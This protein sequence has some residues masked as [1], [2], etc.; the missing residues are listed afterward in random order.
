MNMK[1]IL[2]IILSIGLAVSALAGCGT[3]DETAG[4]G[5]GAGADET[6]VGTTTASAKESGE[7]TEITGDIEFLERPSL[8]SGE[9]T[10]E[11]DPDLKPDVAAYTVDDDFGNIIN[12]DMFEYASD[13]YKEAIKENLFVV[14]EEFGREFFEVYESNAY[15]QTPNF[16]TVDSLMHTYHIYFAH[17]LK[18][19]EKNYLLDSLKTLSNNMFA[20]SVEKYDE[21]KGTSFEDAAVRNVAYFAVACSLLG[22][23]VSIPDYAADIVSEETEKIMAADNIYDSSLT[24]TMEDYSQYKPRGYYDEDDQ[25]KKYFRT[26]MWYGRM[27]FPAKEAEM[28]KTA[29]L[30]TLSLDESAKAEWEAIYA[31]T[32]FF[33][34]ASD[35]LGY[36]EYLP[37]IKECYGEDLSA[38]A[39]SGNDAAFDKFLT[40]VQNMDAPQIQS[41]PVWDDEENVIPGFRLMGQ[42][43]TIDGAI[44]QNLIYRSVGEN[45]N[46]ERRNLPDAL[47]V[48][49]ALGSDVARDIVLKEGADKF[50]DYTTRLEEV[51]ET[52]NNSDEKLW[53][54]SLYSQWLNTLRPLLNEKGEGY[55][56]FMQSAEWTKKT[57]ETFAG[58]YT[59]LKHDTV[60]YAKQPMAEMG[61]G[62]EEDIDDRGYVEPEPLVY[63]RFMS[64]ADN[65]AEGLKKYKMISRDDEENLARLSALAEKLL[66][67][68][69]KELTG[70]LPTDE[71]FDLIRDYGGNIEHFWYEVMKADNGLDYVSSE[72]FPAA[73]VVDVATDPNGSVLEIG[74]GNPREISVVVPVDGKLRIA[75]GSVYNFYQFEQPLSERL[76]DNEWRKMCGAMP[77]EG[78][79]YERDPDLDNPEWTKSYRVIRWNYYE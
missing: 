24:G 44:M 2:S 20:A 58:S 31:V 17:L 55:P 74:C 59:E 3:S 26:M 12:K 70:E 21:Y 61:G 50:P 34:G 73:L 78:W 19:I 35:D 51:R 45:Q 64:L 22:E 13:E 28:T 41:I 10:V 11:Y 1:K 32:S 43:F 66:V 4:N 47:D 23:K 36:C 54:A 48:P 8:I 33:S 9:L 75:T 46:E 25:L 52:F 60:L 71:E 63:A 14:G 68:S 72:E 27:T 79:E 57:L 39:I 16:V 76:T 56:S 30:M 7:S 6:T 77:G 62:Y 67:I 65:T 42:R 5:T 37:A 69:Q 18:V 15:S 49:A 53:S 40:A 38:S 29:L